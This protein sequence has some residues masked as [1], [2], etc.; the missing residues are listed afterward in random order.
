MNDVCRITARV[1]IH[2]RFLVDVR[3]SS[4]ESRLQSDSGFSDGGFL[5]RSRVEGQG[6]EERERER[7]GGKKHKTT[8]HRQQEALVLLQRQGQAVAFLVLRIVA[9]VQNRLA[10]RRRG[11]L[12]FHLKVKWK[13]S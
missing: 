3:P 13:V 7:G 2:A 1:R 10:Q 6:R 9:Q 4:N 8:A 5:V 12:G 11:A